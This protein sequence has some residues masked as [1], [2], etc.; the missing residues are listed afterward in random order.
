[1]G[2]DANLVGKLEPAAGR[3]IV[4]TQSA[5]VYTSTQT[6]LTIVPSS[7]IVTPT[8]SQATVTTNTLQGTLTDGFSLYTL[9]SA[10]EMPAG[11][12]VDAAQANLWYAAR[13][14]G[15]MGRISLNAQEPATPTASPTATH[16]PT[17]TRTASLTATHTP[18][19]TR[20]ASPTATHTPTVTRTP[21]S[22]PSATPTRTLTPFVPRVRVFLPILVRP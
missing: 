4:S 22:G 17:P 9:P 11:V 19:P 8:V 6:S 3:P 13:E 12:A 21:T 15:R 14:V 5:T 2:G 7:Y 20:T 18:T 1:M 10:N 16:T